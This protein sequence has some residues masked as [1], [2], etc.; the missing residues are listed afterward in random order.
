[1]A[2]GGPDSLDDVEPF[3]LDVRGGRPTS[4]ELIEE[5]RARYAAIGGAS[6]LLAWTE[7]QARA[8]GELLDT[9]T[10]GAYRVYV[11]MRHWRPRIRDAIGRIAAA[12]H[13][14][15]IA[16]CLAPHYSRLSIG[17]YQ[18]AVAA[19]QRELGTALEVIEVDSWHLEPA[20]V[21]TLAERALAGLE[22]FGAGERAAVHVLFTA[23]S[24]PRRAL[25]ADDPYERQ[26]RE[27][28]AA[29]AAR[30]SAVQPWS[31]CYQSAGASSTPWLGPAIEEVIAERAAAGVESLLVATIGFVCDHVEILYDLDIEAREQARK[32]DLRLER[33]ESLNVAPGF[34][35]A[36][37]AVVRRAGERAARSASARHTGGC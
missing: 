27:T 10:P 16:L 26:L 25:A 22:L 4:R 9:E 33:T 17:A 12:G 28:A 23:H 31:F 6:P 3:L 20:L 1:M 29:V 36:L 18:R 13:R 21:E 8:L 37:A 32:L 14:R 5:I 34:I 11:G 15:V 24:L 7:A 30:L 2:Y 35:A 19:A